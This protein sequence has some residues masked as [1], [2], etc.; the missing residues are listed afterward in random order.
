MAMPAIVEQQSR[1]RTFDTTI[2]DNQQFPASAVV[3]LILWIGCLLVGSLGIVLPY[4][5]PVAKEKQPPSVT[6]EMLQVELTTD[7]LPPILPQPGLTAARPPDLEPLATAVPE[8]PPLTPVAEPSA[9]AFALPVEGPVVVVEPAKASFTASARSEAKP[10]AAPPVRVLTYGQGEGRQ[11]APEY[12]LRSRLEGQE[13]TV[14]I[15]FSVS[16]DGRVLAAD[17]F[18]PSPWKAL[19][20]SAL[21]TLRERWRF[22]SGP[23]RLYEVSIRFQLTK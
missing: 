15:R 17:A 13:G 20:D 6:A 18:S 8:V 2:A 21:R 5:R 11:P 4:A 23:V 14:G 16:E 7:P 10:V 3:T 9:V 22:S 12:P 19:N 1:R